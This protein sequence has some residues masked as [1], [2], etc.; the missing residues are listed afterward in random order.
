MDLE[1]FNAT[2][3]AVDQ[4]NSP[5]IELHPLAG[6]FHP[7]SVRNLDSRSLLGKQQAAGPD[8]RP[9][10]DAAR[11]EPVKASISEHGQRS[12]SGVVLGSEGFAVAV[13]EFVMHRL[14][15][16]GAIA[17]RIEGHSRGRRH[18]RIGA[19]TRIRDTDCDDG[20]PL[21]EQLA[22]LQ[23]LHAAAFDAVVFAGVFVENPQRHSAEV[24]LATVRA[25][26][27]VLG[28]DFDVRRVSG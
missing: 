11:I 10:L 25:A 17:G 22:V 9:N 7:G 18:D 20:L 8:A 28:A 14:V 2:D 15:G 1:R 21:A 4:P 27:E 3:S 5:V 24:G 26:H 19:V 16:P 23:Q 6:P 13:A 12:G